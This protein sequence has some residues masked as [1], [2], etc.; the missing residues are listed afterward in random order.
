M[1][2]DSKP[3]HDGCSSVRREARICLP[4][5]ACGHFYIYRGLTIRTGV[6]GLPPVVVRY[7]EDRLGRRS[8]VPA[9]TPEVEQTRRPI[10]SLLPIKRTMSLL[11]RTTVADYPVFLALKDVLPTNMLRAVAFQK[12]P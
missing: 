2:L 3:T 8:E 5:A 9:V 6:T 11:P 12:S 1:V 4:R 7:P 10:D